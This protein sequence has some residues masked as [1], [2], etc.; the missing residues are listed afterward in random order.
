VVLLEPP[1]ILWFLKRSIVERQKDEKMN[2]RF[3]YQTKVLL[4]VTFMASL[5]GCGR[6]HLK[7]RLDVTDVE[8]TPVKRQS[9]GNCW[10]YATSTWA[11][12]LHLS[13][14]GQTVNISESY[15]TYW[16]WYEKILRG[17]GDKIDTGGEWWLASRIIQN[18]GYMLEGDFLPDEADEQMSAVQRMAEFAI[19]ESLSSGSLQNNSNRTPESVKAALN[20]AFGVDMDA[21]SERIYAATELKT[22]TSPGGSPWTL[23]DEI[24]GGAHAWTQLSYPQLWGQGAEPRLWD[25][26]KRSSVLQRV[27][28]AANDK[29]PVIMSSMV[30]FSALNTENNATFEHELYLKKG[31]S[32]GQ[33]G[34]LIVLEDYVVD[35][36]PGV[37]TIPEGDV[38]DELKNAALNGT[39]RYL[40]VKNSWGTDRPDRGLSD[41]YTRF[42][43]DFLNKPLPFGL[44]HGETD[45]SKGTWYS[46]LSGFIV[47]PEY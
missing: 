4:L 6:Q 23:S 18:H 42:T 7:A 38:S 29:K 22:G 27:L 5:G 34:H 3:F 32:T 17:T 30:E 26:R 35:H 45:I 15:W 41:G 37:G 19:N 31:Y 24:S 2:K 20:E 25:R 43:M 47:P 40:V 28:R 36:V 46:A 11:E 13:A 12:S 10:L 8:H 33:G 14:S 44:E 16:D 21:L 39:L 1:M 9:I